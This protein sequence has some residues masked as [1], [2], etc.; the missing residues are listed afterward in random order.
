MIHD[1][2]WIAANMT[3]ANVDLASLHRTDFTLP[4]GFDPNNIEFL[5]VKV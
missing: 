2:M 1:S 4:K 3:G 5:D